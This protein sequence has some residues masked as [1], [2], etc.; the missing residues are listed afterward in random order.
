M[1]L[2]IFGGGESYDN[3]VAYAF[4]ISCLK[5]CEAAE[6]ACSVKLDENSEGGAEAGGVDVVWSVK[7]G[8]H[9]GV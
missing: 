7:E 4:E 6:T 1:K 2:V 5:L 8:D 9:K 3:I